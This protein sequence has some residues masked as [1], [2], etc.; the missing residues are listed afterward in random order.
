MEIDEHLWYFVKKQMEK[1]VLV[2][3]TMVQF[4]VYVWLTEYV[5]FQHRFIITFRRSKSWFYSFFHWG[6]S[7]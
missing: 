4:F 3:M 2:L 6:N 7:S 5:K 1:D